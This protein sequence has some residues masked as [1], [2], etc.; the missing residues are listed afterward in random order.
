MRILLAEDDNFLANGLCMALQQNG[1]AVDRVATG[2]D[3]DTALNVASYDLLILD[4]GLPI[5][6]GTEVLK[7]LRNKG[8][9]LP[10]LVLTA[11]DSLADRVGGLD[12]GAN[13]YLTKP[14]E[15]AELEA[16]IRALLRKEH[17]NNRMEITY[18]PIRFDTVN[19][20]CTVNG[21]AV[22]LSPREMV[23]LEI[24]LQGG[25]RIVSKSQINEHLSSWNVDLTNNAIDIAMHRLRKKFDGSGVNI[26]TIRG[27]GYLIENV[28]EKKA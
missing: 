26:R 13:D 4:L 5:L 2:L 12:L 27:L 22:E 9:L 8:L 24:L 16:R 11:R 19:R 21:A 25:G 28:A 23:M 14:F 10:V 1:Y 3:A 17:W 15:L 18:G 7:R 6:D 20:A